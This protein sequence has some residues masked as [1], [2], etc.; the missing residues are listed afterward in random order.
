[1]KVAPGFFCSAAAICG[2][3]ADASFKHLD[4]LSVIL[5]KFA[6]RAGKADGKFPRFV[7]DPIALAAEPN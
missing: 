4:E 1:M 5:A 2:S 6:G 7:T 3:A